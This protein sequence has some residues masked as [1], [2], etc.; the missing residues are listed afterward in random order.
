MIKIKTFTGYSLQQIDNFIELFLGENVNIDI[1]GFSH[2]KS[3]EC[4]YATILYKNKVADNV[5]TLLNEG[6][7]TSTYFA[8]TTTGTVTI[9]GADKPVKNGLICQNNGC[10]GDLWDSEPNVILT[11]DPAQKNVHCGDCEYKGTR[12]I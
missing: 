7:V 5:K 1:I 8:A 12:F 4:Y 2:N 11:S 3:D 9:T 10:N 6:T